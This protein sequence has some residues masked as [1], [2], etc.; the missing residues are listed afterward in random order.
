M[1][2]IYFGIS[3]SIKQ[4]CYIGIPK[5]SFIYIS[6]LSNTLVLEKESEKFLIDAGVSITFSREREFDIATVFFS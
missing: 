2:L 6:E 1:M 5:S 4:F 3:N